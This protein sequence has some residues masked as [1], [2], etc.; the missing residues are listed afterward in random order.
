MKKFLLIFLVLFV[1]HA[2]AQ[3]M[4]DKTVPP[5]AVN[6]FGKFLEPFQKESLEQK[7]RNYNDSTSS[8]I[9]IITVPD[10]QGYDIAELALK[11]LR[12]WGIGTKDKNNGV[13]I[14]VSKEERKAR[15][16]TGSGMEGVL[17]DILARQI[18]DDRMVPYFKENDYYRGFDNAIDAIIQAAAGEYKATPAHKNGGPSF[19]TIFILVIIFFVII[20][21]LGGGGG[22][23]SY[24]SRR[25]SRGLGGL[26][27]FIAGNL[28]GGGG[29]GG[30]GFGG[31]F[32]GGGGGGGFG[33]F[34]GGGGGGGGA[35]GGW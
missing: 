8:A 10:L 9:V 24:M 16:E 32:G 2:G 30:G 33:G 34:G 29:R 3:K 5:Q 15:I 7:I 18:I 23:G 25:G 21:F 19:K 26:P 35:S 31:G 27:W 11:Y 6:D 14:L 13:L 1:N 12:G 22:G 20:S 17:P 28:L 4:F